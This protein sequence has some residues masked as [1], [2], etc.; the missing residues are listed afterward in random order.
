MFWRKKAPPPVI[1]PPVQEVKIPAYPEDN[2][3]ILKPVWKPDVIT[4]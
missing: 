3:A 2:V 4:S 1:R